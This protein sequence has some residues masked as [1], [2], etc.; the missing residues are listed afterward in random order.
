MLDT[1]H[2]QFAQILGLHDDIEPG[3]YVLEGDVC[4]IGRSSMC[5]VVVQRAIVSR[6]HAKIERD[7]PRYVLYDAGSANGTY[8]NT[9]RIYEPHLLKDRDMIGLGGPT[10]L[11]R[12]RDPDPTLIPAFRLTF[13]EP[14]MTFSLNKKPVDLTPA[15]FRL[16]HYLYQHAG[17]VCTRE[18]CAQAIWGRDYDPGLDADAL[19]RAMSNLRGQLRQVDSETDLIETRRGLGYVLTP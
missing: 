15:Q 8:V 6:L 4:T 13:S 19:D 11:I 18:S 14:A 12:F 10:A 7:G 9:R 2:F 1:G 16:L 5:H 3:E 17:E